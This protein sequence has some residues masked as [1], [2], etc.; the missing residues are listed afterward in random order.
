MENPGFQIPNY[1]IDGDN[2]VMEVNIQRFFRGGI[3]LKFPQVSVIETY[4]DGLTRLLA[5]EPPHHQE[6]EA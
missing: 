1:W 2:A 6:S 5:Y 3:E 4:S